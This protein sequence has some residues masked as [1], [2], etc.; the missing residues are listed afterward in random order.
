MSPD[1]CFL[2]GTMFIHV[3][4][5]VLSQECEV[6]VEPSTEASFP[7]SMLVQDSISGMVLS[8]VLVV[9]CTAGPWTAS[10]NN[11][12]QAKNVKVHFFIGLLLFFLFW[13]D[14]AKEYQLVRCESNRPWKYLNFHIPEWLHIGF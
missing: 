4:S 7:T 2:C 14:S 8:L 12:M 3:R 6:I 5:V 1:W 11:P 13:L 9:D 10:N